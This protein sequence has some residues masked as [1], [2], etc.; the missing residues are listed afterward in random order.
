MTRV[1]IVTRPD[2]YHAMAVQWGLSKLG[3]EAF[4]WMPTDLPDFCSATISV[5]RASGRTVVHVRQEGV[6]TCLSDF[7]VVWNRRRGRP[8]APAHASP[9]DVM[10]IEVECLQ[11][12]NNMLTLLAKQMPAVNDPTYQLPADMKAV[13]LHTALAVGLDVPDTIVTNDFDALSEFGAGSRNLISKPYK[14]HFWYTGA[15]NVSQ[16]TAPVP[17]LGDIE[18]LAIELCPIIIQEKLVRAFEVRLIVFGAEV[19]GVKIAGHLEDGHLDSRFSVKRKETEFSL[20]EVP[21]DIVAKCREYLSE[22]GIVFGAFDFLIDGAGRWIFLECNEAG[23]FLFLEQRLPETLI[24]DKFCRW[25]ASFGKLG[26]SE[27]SEG[28]VPTTRA[29]EVSKEAELLVASQ[30]HHKRTD[31]ND[32]LVREGATADKR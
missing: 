8:V 20:V 28:I 31:K 2:D 25:L 11:H 17:G 24:L 18:R 5:D 22:T 16:L 19:V 7:D 23:Q 15:E 10:P 9:H 29:F 21:N 30:N 14:P 3:C 27:G 4:V 32:L 26:R 1:L 6:Q 13:Q 12:V